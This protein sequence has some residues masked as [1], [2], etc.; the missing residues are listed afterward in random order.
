MNPKSDLHIRHASSVTHS[1]FAAPKYGTDVSSKRMDELDTRAVRY[2]LNLERKRKRFLNFVDLGAGLGI[3]SV[4]MAL[5]G[6]QSFAY[7]LS[8]APQTVASIARIYH[9]GRL[10]YITGDLGALSIS[11]FPRTVDI[12]YSQRFIHY[13]R[14]DRATQ[15]LQKLNQRMKRGAPLFLSAAG[16]D[17]ELAQAHPDRA[18]PVTDRFSPIVSEVAL[19]HSVTAPLCIYR[20]EDLQML[21]RMA[22]FRTVDCWVTEF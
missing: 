22:G 2:S 13:L 9:V 20:V 6:Y 17:T 8:V 18:K 5:N 14:F 16:F 10:K 7:D 4:R 21:T 3:Q 19:K 11:A 1:D 12:L 15:L